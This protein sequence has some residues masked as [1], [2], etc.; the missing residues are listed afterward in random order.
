MK[1]L[2]L[3]P[4][5]F[6]EKRILLIR[7]HKVMI[8]TDIAVL[9]DVSTKVLNQAVKRNIE[10]FPLDFMFELTSEEKED[11]VTNCDHLLNELLNYN[12]CRIGTGSCMQ[13]AI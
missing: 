13:S 6:L 12:R 1:K 9:Y 4:Q 11:V 10:R 3:L 8:D 2:S 7:D 5:A